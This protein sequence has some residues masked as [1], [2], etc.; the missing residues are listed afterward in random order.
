MLYEFSPIHT[1]P[2]KLPTMTPGSLNAQYVHVNRFMPFEITSPDMG[3]GLIQRFHWWDETK[4]MNRS[5]GQDISSGEFGEIG[6]MNI[7]YPGNL[8]SFM[9]LFR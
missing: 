3:T 9:N 6:V 8:E 1:D 7:L 2:G 5:F 4:G